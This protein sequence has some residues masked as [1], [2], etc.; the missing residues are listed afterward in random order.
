M[1]L[2]ESQLNVKKLWDKYLDIV[3]QVNE[4]NDSSEDIRM[5]YAQYLI[6][7]KYPDKYG[8]RNDFCDETGI[9]IDAYNRFREGLGINRNTL[10][11][12]C[13]GLNLTYEESIICYAMHGYFLLVDNYLEQTLLF[14]L[15]FLNDEN[16]RKLKSTERM[17]KIIKECPGVDKLY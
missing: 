10:F 4:F 5:R 11:K 14:A 12:I 16:F 3:K 7:E 9:S 2:P 17:E 1:L 6:Q 13:V 15:S 8:R